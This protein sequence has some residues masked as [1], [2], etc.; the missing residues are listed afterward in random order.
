M[1]GRTSTGLF[2]TCIGSCCLAIFSTLVV[3]D[4]AGLRLV[5]DVTETTVS[6]PGSDSPGTKQSR[7]VMTVRLGPTA[8]ATREDGR[9]WIYDFPSRRVDWLDHEG[10]KRYVSS[11]Y[12][13]PAFREMELVNRRY[14]AEILKALGQ[15]SD[16]VD[17]EIELGVVGDPPAKARLQETRR[18]GSRAFS[19]NGREVTAFLAAD[20]PVPSELQAA[21]A[22]WLLYDAKLHPLVRRELGKD[23]R[24][25]Q[26]LEFRWEF[27][28][29]STGIV[30]EMREASAEPF[31]AAAARAEYAE[32]PF[33]EKGI[34]ALAHQVTRGEKG[35]AP[36]AQEYRA[37]AEQL[38]ADGRGLEA[39]LVAT[40]SSFAT[41]E[42][43]EELLARI[44]N[45]FR[46]DPGVRAVS[47]AL[48][49]EKRDPA[50]ALRELGN[51]VGEGIEGA[52]GMAILRAN[53]MLRLRQGPKALAEFERALAGN[54]FLAGAWIDAGS[55]YFN[56]YQTGKAWVCWDAA[57]A[58]GAGRPLLERIDQTEAELLRRFPEFF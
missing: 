37:R 54:P 24:L 50:Q 36:A 38:L 6:P 21:V 47:R 4:A 33:E 9:E 2:A 3:A 49:I 31:D 13:Q 1:R 10:R 15:E 40:E 29:T 58:I 16:P 43:P 12:A 22:H 53:Q 51:V 42:V 35:P 17:A 27:A 45:R 20:T 8:F 46:A 26:R 39:F 48:A 55:I 41:G 44:G 25:P 7:K 5:Y 34:L 28:K 18:D 23:P 14:T 56:G 30:W 52:P 32:A 11:L 57:R 19:L